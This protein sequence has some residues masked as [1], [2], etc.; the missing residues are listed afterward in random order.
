[1][2]QHQIKLFCI[3][4]ARLWKWSPWQKFDMTGVNT[5]RRY[6]KI[7]LNTKIYCQKQSLQK[8]ASVEIFNS[9]CVFHIEHLLFICIYAYI[10]AYI[11]TFQ[12]TYISSFFLDFYLLAIAQ[13]VRSFVK[14]T[15][16]FLKKLRFLP[17]LPHGNIMCTVGA[18]LRYILINRAQRVFLRF[19]KDEGVKKKNIL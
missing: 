18:Q 5:S 8:K 16:N 19:W 17:K 12:Y 14:G 11:Y 9:K 6:E 4:L 1:M 7:H 10:Y 2:H 3:L 13:A 15:Y